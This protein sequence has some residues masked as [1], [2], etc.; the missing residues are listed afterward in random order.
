MRSLD[1]SDLSATYLSAPKFLHL[2]LLGWD[3]V[4][5]LLNPIALSWGGLQS[6]PNA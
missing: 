5:S 6:H 4:C 2:M 3:F 1:V